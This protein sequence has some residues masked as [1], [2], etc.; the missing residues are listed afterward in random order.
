MKKQFPMLA[1]TLLLAALAGCATPQSQPKTVA[2]TAAAHPQLA[3]L[4]RLLDQAGLAPTLRGSGPYT[5][6]APSDEAFRALPAAELQALAGDRERLKELLSY[7]VLPTRTASSEVG[8]G[9]A[10]TVQ[11]GEV[12]LSR[13]GSFVTVED[14]M[15]T[16]ADVAAANGVVHVID[17]VLMPPK[18]K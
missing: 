13:A 4:S 1:A 15:V 17:R 9:S 12:A 5:V 7:H 18:K 16:Q 3:T 2:D 11:G 14:A 8:V 10:K 6:F